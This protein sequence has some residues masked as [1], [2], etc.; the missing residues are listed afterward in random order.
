MSIPLK[1][2]A[3]T[4]THANSDKNK[5]IFIAA[6]AIWGIKSEKLPQAKFDEIKTVLEGWLTRKYGAYEGSGFGDVFMISMDP[7]VLDPYYQKKPC[8]LGTCMVTN[9]AFKCAKCKEAMYCSKEHQR[10]D[11]SRHK[12]ECISPK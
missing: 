5:Q 12:V 7:E 6:E 3:V 1:A 9:A 8:S 4:I 10:Q 2:G 11:W